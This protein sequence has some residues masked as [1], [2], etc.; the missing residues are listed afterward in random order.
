MTEEQY[1][2]NPEGCIPK[3]LNSW[4]WFLTSLQLKHPVHPLDP[5]APESSEFFI[6][7]SK[8]RLRI[9]HVTPENVQKV[10]HSL[11]LHQNKRTS[12]SEEYWFTKWNKPLKIGHCNCSFRRSQR[13]SLLSNQGLST[14]NEKTRERYVICFSCFALIT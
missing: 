10:R 7:D 2:S 14:Q 3:V 12:L 13:Y 11:E 6:I 4:R 8:I 5:V 9:I 1:L